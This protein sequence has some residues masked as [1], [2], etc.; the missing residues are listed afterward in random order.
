ME[1]IDISVLLSIVGIITVLTNIITQVL[2]KITWDKVPTN[3]VA[4]FVAEVLTISAGAAYAQINGISVT[5]YMVVAAVV[6]GFMAAYA[7]MFGLDKP[8]ELSKG[9]THE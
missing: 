3:L 1:I 2:K 4:L 8:H 6:V 7:A 5:W 9:R